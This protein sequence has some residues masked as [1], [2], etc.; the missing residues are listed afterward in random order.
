MKKA[1]SYV[2][3]SKTSSKSVCAKEIHYFKTSCKI[4]LQRIKDTLPHTG[5]AKVCFGRR[6]RHLTSG[7]RFKLF[8]PLNKSAS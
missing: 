3:I 7:Q 6:I 1:K 2:A 5:A 8:P 4:G